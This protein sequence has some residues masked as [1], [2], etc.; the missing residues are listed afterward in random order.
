MTTVQKN[1]SA[2]LRLQS[3]PLKRIQKAVG[4]GATLFDTVYL[5]QDLEQE[6]NENEMTNDGENK[7]PQESEAIVSS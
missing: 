7:K 5:F 3:F 6:G 4:A 2:Y 1:T